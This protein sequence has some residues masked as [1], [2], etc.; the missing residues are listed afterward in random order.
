MGE[1]GLVIFKKKKKVFHSAI[2]N[3]T[4]NANTPDRICLLNSERLRLDHSIIKESKY[5]ENQERKQL[6]MAHNQTVGR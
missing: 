2:R 3:K 1:E 5:R 4:T 6:I